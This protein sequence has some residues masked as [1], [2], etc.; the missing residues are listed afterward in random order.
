MPNGYHTGSINAKQRASAPGALRKRVENGET[1]PEG[2]RALVRLGP[3]NTRILTGEDDLSSWDD[4]ELMHG[5]KRDKNGGW[6]GSR[7]T[8][9]PIAIHRELTKRRMQK[10]ND[11]LRENIVE[12]MEQLILIVKGKDTED[13]DRLRAIEMMANRVMGKEPIRVEVTGETSTLDEDLDFIT[14]YDDDEFIDVE[15][16]EVYDDETQ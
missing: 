12:A 6:Q 16:T 9:V 5:A 3:R 11:L 4:D 7:P 13:K 8:V 14:T 2:T 10:A 15:A 1:L